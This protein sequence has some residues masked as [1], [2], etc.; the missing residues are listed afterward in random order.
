MEKRPTIVLATDSLA[1]S[2]V[3]E[4]ML[5]LACV[6]RHD[7]RI[8]LAFPD[9]GEATEFLARAQ[10]IGCEAMTI[11]HDEAAMADR[12]R[13][14]GAAVLHIH[15]GVAW[16]GHGL[17]KAG[18]VAGVPTVRTE[19]LPYVLTDELQKQEHLHSVS[20]V[21]RTI[22][23]SDATHD[24]YRRVGASGRIA[25]TIRNGI[26]RPQPARDRAQTRSLLGIPDDSPVVVTIARFTPQ[27]G[28]E[29][30]LPAA[31]SVA[32]TFPQARF[33]LIGDGPERQAMERLAA[34]LGIAEQVLFL[35]QRGDVPDL[36]AAADVFVL[37]SLFEGLPLV[38]LEAM[39]LDL[40]VVATRIGGTSEALGQD[41]PLLVEPGDPVALAEAIATTL[42]NGAMRGGL[43][44]RNRHRYE[45][46]FMAERMAAQ[47]ADL[48]RTVVA[49]GTLHA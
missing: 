16:E 37:A 11:C 39:A 20:L 21:D 45:H 4:H 43:G 23:V 12:L 47:T 48:Y 25:V 7:H 41:Y 32:V 35:G 18:R 9:A 13:E 34:E 1:P 14:I 36:L 27:K 8:V 28:Y 38:V 3:G 33:L 6:L 22:F 49:E 17:A 15:A 5:T 42:G 40:P 2:G 30:L 26:A 29:H 44:S 46:E 19:H 24:T 10:G 31:A